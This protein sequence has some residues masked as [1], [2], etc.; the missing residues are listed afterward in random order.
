MCSGKSYMDENSHHKKW[1]TVW[2]H[3]L[4]SEPLSDC[5]SEEVNH[6]LIASLKKWTTVWLHLIRSEPLS[7]CI[8]EE[9]NH[10][11]IA[12]LKKWTTVWLHL[13]R[14]EPLSDCISST[15]SRPVLVERFATSGINPWEPKSVAIYIISYSPNG[16]RT[17]FTRDFGIIC[18]SELIIR[19]LWWPFISQWGTTVLSHNR[20][21]QR[22]YSEEVG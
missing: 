6:C 13:W 8:S 10:C 21:P 19:L 16:Y 4:R 12:S 2:L 20:Y 17:L 22:N 15:R 7:D 5:I 11:L 1:T 18:I 3:L 9:V 14:S